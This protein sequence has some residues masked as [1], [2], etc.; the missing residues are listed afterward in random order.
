MSP[1]LRNLPVIADLYS[2]LPDKKNRLSNNVRKESLQLGNR[3]HK[4]KNK[5]L[6]LIVDI[7]MHR[8]EYIGIGIIFSFDLHGCIGYIGW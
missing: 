2:R 8:L 3:I 4:V 5:S 7:Y 1:L 6:S